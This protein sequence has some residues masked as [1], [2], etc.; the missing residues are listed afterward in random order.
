MSLWKHLYDTY[1]CNLQLY[2]IRT[3]KELE[4][5]RGH[6][7]DVTCKLSN[8]VMIISSYMWKQSLYRSSVSVHW[9]GLMY[10]FSKYY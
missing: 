9:L 1:A 3:M 6:K 10:M 5:F 4:S 2:D 7:K 8:Y